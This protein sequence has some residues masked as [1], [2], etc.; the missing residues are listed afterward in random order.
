VEDVDK[1]YQT[2]CE[3]GVS[4]DKEPN[5]TPWGGRIALFSDPDGNLLQLVQIDWR[6]YFSA[7]AQSL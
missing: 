2:L 1:A 3:K 5:D 4:F 7:S 6:K